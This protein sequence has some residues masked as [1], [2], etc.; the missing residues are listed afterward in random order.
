MNHMPRAAFVAA[1]L[2]AAALP[3]AAQTDS[4]LHVSSG[5][6]LRLRVNRD[7][8]LVAGGAA[9]D[10][11]QPDVTGR[12]PASG[13]GTRMMWY[14]T[15][16]AFRAGVAHGTEW[17]DLQVG[18]FSF[19]AGSGPTASGRNS[20]ALGAGARATGAS[21]VALG[22]NTLASGTDALSWGTNTTA[23]AISSAALGSYANATHAGS[24]VFGDASSPLSFP[25]VGSTAANSFTVRAAGGTT[26]YS[27]GAMGAG[28]RLAAGGSSWDVVSDRGR[29][30]NFVS[31]SDDDVL[32]RI[33]RVPVSSWNYIAQGRR[34]RHI[35]PMAQD[36]ERAFALSGDSLTINSG[37][38]DGVNL[39]GIQALDRRTTE[40]REENA[41]LR[42]EVRALRSANATLE[43][44]LARVEALLS[45][46]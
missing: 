29:K 23:S 37:D 10:N 27:N 42:A 20:V 22:G 15:K 35:G 25:F 41:A 7:G 19:A 33:R 46:P 9:D 16:G 30:E 38:F 28:V 11:N 21:A 8:G 12:I 34:V 3:A 45:R 36:W 14:P 44:R 32:S 40:L 18:Y 26:I 43:A 4:L 31:L 24:L 1:A 2:L 6:S 5:D 39:A 13:A 17:D